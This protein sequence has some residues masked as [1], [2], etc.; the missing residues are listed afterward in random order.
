MGVAFNSKCFPISM[1]QSMTGFVSH[2]VELSGFTVIWE[3]KTLN[4]RFLDMCVKLPENLRSIEFELRNMAKQRIRRGKM[5]VS[6]FIRSKN[7]N[8]VLCMS[9]ER[10]NEIAQIFGRAKQ[11]F[12]E[13]GVDRVNVE[14]CSIFANP[15][16]N[17]NDNN[18]MCENFKASVL[19]SFEEVLDKLTQARI[20]EGQRLKLALENCL[21]NMKQITA[22]ICL[23]TRDTKQKAFKKLTDRV[24]ELAANVT[25]D[26]V[27]MEQEILLIAQKADI[28]E[29]LD[30]L[31]SHY[32]EITT[33]LSSTEQ[34][35]RKLDFLMQELNRESNTICSKATDINIINNAISLKTCIEQMREQIQNIE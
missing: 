2:E 21:C 12:A 5:D 3:V 13:Q 1:L 35:G 9:D 26:Q 29:E 8:D 33:I 15:V 17:G 25:I 7:L 11:A 16:F 6:L 24:A 28:Q 23:F 10:I 14:L 27:R 19:A 34:V 32:C 4:H 22:E 18:R 31:N 30:R 20:D